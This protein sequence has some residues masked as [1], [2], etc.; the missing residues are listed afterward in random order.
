MMEHYGHM[1][2]LTEAET[3]KTEGGMHLGIDATKRLHCSR[4]LEQLRKWEFDFGLRDK[5]PKSDHLA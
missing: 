3:R 4:S 1:E 2:I 5:W